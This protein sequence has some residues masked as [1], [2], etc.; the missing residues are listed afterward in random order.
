[1]ERKL[2]VLLLIAGVVHAEP[3]TTGDL[4]NDADWTAS[5]G[6]LDHSDYGH[7]H[8]DW[9]GGT[10]EQ[11]IDISEYTGIQSIK[12]FT[13]AYACENIIGGHCSSGNYDTLTVTLT[14][15]NGDIFTETYAVGNQWQEY[16]IVVT[17]SSDA[18]TL[19]VSMYGVDEGYWGGWYGPVAYNGEL[20]VT[21]DPEATTV[22]PA[23]EDPTLQTTVLDQVYNPIPEIPQVELPAVEVQTVEATP[24]ET[25]V[26]APQTASNESPASEAP[27][28]AESP[29]QSDT[30]GSSGTS[31]QKEQQNSSSPA[32]NTVIT[33]VMTNVE[34]STT[35]MDSLPGDPSDPVTQVIAIAIMAAQGV[36]IEDAKLE[37]P[38]LPKG[39][40]IRD[41]RRL[42]D[43]MWMNALASDAKFDKYMVEAQ[44]QN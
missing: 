2:L 10:I 13:D 43:R 36:E 16:D 19:T 26:E 34:I 39:V 17:P 40:T 7:V 42:A 11:T 28:Q 14:L 23:A 35:S 15:D 32:G 6:V 20:N 38:E 41:N 33:T 24:M 29:S 25:P 22:V 31:D 9:T 30:G 37:Q 3:I 12:Y 21:Y 44:W 4:L 8:F 1:M 5:G 18:T 27:A